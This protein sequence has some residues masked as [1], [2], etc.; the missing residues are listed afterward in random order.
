MKTTL[1]HL[2]FLG[3]GFISLTVLTAVAAPLVNG[4]KLAI[5]QGAGSAINLPC[6]SG[7]CFGME[8]APGMII[9]IDIGPGTD[10]G[11]IVGKAQASGGQELAPSPANTTPGQLSNAWLYFGNY[12]TFST[13]PGGETNIFDDASCT[14]AA[15]VGK[16]ELRAWDVAWNGNIIR[17]GSADGVSNWVIDPVGKKYS[18]D[19]QALVPCWDCGVLYLRLKGSV[20]TGGT[21]VSGFWPATAAPGT[22]IF[23]FGS[24]FAYG[25]NTK[26]SVNGIPAPL[27]LVIDPTVLVFVLPEGNTTG[28]IT[29]TTPDSTATSATSFGI[30]INGVGITGFWPAQGPIGSV[31][32]VF[33]GGF[34]PQG[35]QVAVNGVFTPIVQVL[36]SGLALFV[37]PPGATTGPVSVKTAAGQATS[38]APFVVVP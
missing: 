33:G 31:S 28:P 18:L 15:C 3:I 35:T 20:I 32:F 4:T 14:G 36:D 2:L 22:F 21:S 37:I 23:L 16:T 27:V 26:V 5:T 9:W 13:T 30:P 17:F 1:K 12:G 24:H 38:T 8:V 6:S 19:Y 7:S 34:V 29:V 10:G 25:Q 11:V